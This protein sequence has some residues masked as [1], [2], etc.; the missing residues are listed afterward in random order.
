MQ[1]GMVLPGTGSTSPVRQS[2]TW[3]RGW[4]ISPGLSCSRGVATRS[5]R[6]PNAFPPAGRRPR[7]RYGTAPSCCGLPTRVGRRGKG[8]DEGV[9]VRGGQIVDFIPVS[10]GQHHVGIDAG[11]AH[12]E[13]RHHH[14]VQLALFHGR[15]AL[16]FAR[17]HRGF[18][19]AHGVFRA[20]KVAQEVLVPLDVGAQ[21][22]GAPEAHDA[23]HV[24]FV[25]RGLDGHAQVA[26]LQARHG[27]PDDLLVLVAP[28][29][30]ALRQISREFSWNCG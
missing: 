24:V 18:P 11:R 27:M 17:L 7:P 14:E 30:S 15:I 26:G 22:V 5:L 25:R 13:F 3:P 9:H 4:A 16:E 6:V 1:P 29:A 12:A 21:R 23:W 28:S 19:A 8:M 10:R 2:R 20:Q